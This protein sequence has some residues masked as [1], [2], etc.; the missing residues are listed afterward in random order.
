MKIDKT[1]VGKRLLVEKLRVAGL[2]EV[3]VLEASPS[4]KRF[5]LKDDMGL[6]F[7]IDG[8]EVTLIEVLPCV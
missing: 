3:T 2:L 5:R 1:M 4:G 6:A 7:W 8:E